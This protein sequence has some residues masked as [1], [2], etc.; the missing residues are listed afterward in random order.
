M[1]NLAWAMVY[2]TLAVAVLPSPLVSAILA[3]YV[4]TSVG[5]L[6]SAV[7]F[8]AYATVSENVL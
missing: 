1:V 2:S 4:P 8:C 6:F 3:V 7:P 5:A